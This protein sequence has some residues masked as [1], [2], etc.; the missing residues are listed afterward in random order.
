MQKAA[1]AGGA[2]AA[3]GGSSTGLIIALVVLVLGLAGAAVWYFGFY[4]TQ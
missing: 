1:R 3:K 4:Q 2:Q